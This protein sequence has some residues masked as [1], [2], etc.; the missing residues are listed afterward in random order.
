MKYVIA[1]VLGAVVGAA[2]L[3]VMACIIVG[4]KAEEIWNDSI[5]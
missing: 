1:F 3:A 2:A 5:K 4:K